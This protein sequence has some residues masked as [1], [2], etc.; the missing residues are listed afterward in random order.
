M[1]IHVQTGKR[2]YSATFSRQFTHG[3]RNDFFLCVFT[4]C[5]DKAILPP[6]YEKD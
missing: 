5:G 6:Q 2:N 3:S 4:F 1:C